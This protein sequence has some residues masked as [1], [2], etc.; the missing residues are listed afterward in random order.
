[1]TVSG[2][3]SMR[4]LSDLPN[5]KSS[6]YKSLEERG[7]TSL[8][9]LR[10]VLV[11]D[12]KTAA[13]LEAISGL[14]PKTIESW[15]NAILDS[16][17][18]GEERSKIIANKG[19]K[20][21]GDLDTQDSEHSKAHKNE[22]ATEEQSHN[23]VDSEEQVR[24]DEGAT[25]ISSPEKKQMIQPRNLFCSI[26]DMHEVKQTLIEL[27]EWNGAKRKGLASTVKYVVQRLKD[28]GLTVTMINDE[29]GDPLVIIASKGEGGMTLWGHLDTE[30]EGN[31]DGALRGIV[32]L[33]FVYGRGVVDMKGA[34]AVLLCAAFRMAKWVVPFSIILTTD[35]LD[36]Q[37]GAQW[38]AYKPLIK[39][40]KGILLLA[41]TE[42]RPV[43]GQVGRLDINVTIF[44]EDSILATSA[45]LDRLVQSRDNLPGQRWLR[46][47]LIR[48]GK[49]GDPFSLA[50][51]CLASFRILTAYPTNDAV[52]T[53]EDILRDRDHLTEIMWRSEPLELDHESWLVK[54]VG[55]IV[56]KE[57]RLY[58]VETEV[59]RLVASNTNICI[60]GPGNPYQSRSANESVVLTDLEKTYELV[61][62][63]V[64]RSTVN[65]NPN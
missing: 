30:R 16:S 17:I 28:A 10:E 25:N 63:V 12:S 11:N 51:S 44:G 15:K 52:D 38:V 5:F 35:A 41:P 65:Q 46:M 32:A 45:F 8:L 13:L 53:L 31:M 62:S 22:V 58:D 60:C 14:G 4:R 55:R 1:M 34:L 39:K 57:P 18:I 37:K 47:G 49:R 3:K 21:N 42:M 50:N 23:R 48:G 61:L 40:S 27:L 9:D 26:D 29:E 33:D 24:S 6:F 7:I 36:K 19:V 2:S 54:E 59:G 43:Y 64:D 20:E 56:G